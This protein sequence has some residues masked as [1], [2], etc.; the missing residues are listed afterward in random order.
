MTSER[1]RQS[2]LMKLHLQSLDHLLEEEDEAERS[3]QKIDTE[4]LFTRS[5]FM[6]LVSGILLNKFSASKPDELSQKAQKFISGVPS[7]VQSGLGEFE[8][9]AKM[10]QLVTEIES[11][12]SLEGQQSQT[13]YS[14]GLARDRDTMVFQSENMPQVE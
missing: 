13:T 1:L 12:F 7:K 9:C 6:G 10:N 11:E 5:Y 4:L 2:K 14:T 3:S 8:I